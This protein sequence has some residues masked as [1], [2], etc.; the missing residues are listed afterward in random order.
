MR[1]NKYQRICFKIAKQRANDEVEKEQYSQALRYFYRVEKVCN[2]TI[3]LDQ[4][5]QLYKT[6][7]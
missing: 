3:S 2:K 7:K 5:L 4:L 6:I 1:L